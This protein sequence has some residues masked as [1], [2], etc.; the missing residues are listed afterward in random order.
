VRIS[1]PGPQLIKS[2]NDPHAGL[3]DVNGLGA[4]GGALRL[5]FTSPRSPLVTDDLSN[6]QIAARLFL[7]ERTVETCVTDTLN[8]LSITEWRHGF[9]RPLRQHRACGRTAHLDQ[10]WLPSPIDPCGVPSP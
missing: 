2:R 6:K 9:A 7:P 1:G 10:L 4:L 8:K 3:V 5:A